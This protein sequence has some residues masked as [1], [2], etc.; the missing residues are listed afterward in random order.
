MNKVLSL[1]SKAVS[2]ETVLKAKSSAS[3]N[4]KTKSGISVF[5]C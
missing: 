3:I 5:A 2:K 1:Q 4:C